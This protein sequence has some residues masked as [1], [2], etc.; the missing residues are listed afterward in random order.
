VTGW[1]DVAGPV[2]LTALAP[3][4]TAAFDRVLAATAV[5][6]LEGPRA[7][8]GVRSWTD[9]FT[10]D[11]ASL[12]D[13]QR[14]AVAAALGDE[15]FTYVVA[16]WASDMH[17]RLGAAWAQLSGSAPAVAAAVDADPAIAPWPAVDE[18]LHVV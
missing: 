10:G 7:E 8:P 16:S 15:L 2:D 13:D 9:Q 18:L 1:A 5:V 12:D 17:R 14:A 11:V 6:D 4:A 3:E